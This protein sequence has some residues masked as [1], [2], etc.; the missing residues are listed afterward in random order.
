MDRRQAIRTLL[1]GGAAPVFLRGARRRPGDKP[2]LLFLWADQ[3]RADTMAAYGNH[4][5]RVPAMNKLASQSVV[6]ERCYASQPVCSPNRSSI[7][8]GLW[9][10][11][12]G[13]TTNNIALRGD[14]PTQPELLNDSDY[15][16]AFMGKWH[17]GD[18]IFPQHG[19]Q[20]WASIDDGYR[21]HYSKGRDPSARSSYYHY[22]TKQGYAPDTDKG[23]SRSFC[24]RLPMEHTKSAYIGQ[25][26]SDFILEN[27]NEP[28]LLNVMFFEPHG[29]FFGPLNDLHTEEEAP[30]PENYP[31]IPIA[32]E[33]KFY[34]DR[35]A[36]GLKDD[37]REVAGQRIH[38]RD[39]HQRANRN[40][41]GLC[42]QVDQALGQILWALEASGQA[43][44][45][46]IVYTADHGEMLGAHGI[47]GKQVMYEESVRVPFLLRVP[48]RQDQS[49]HI[50]RP[51][52]CTDITPTVLEL[53]GKPVP[54]E[55]QGESAAPL[56]EGT[57]RRQEDVFVEW[58]THYNW[59]DQ[60]NGR[61]VISPDGWKLI[62]HDSNENM[63]FN[64][65]QDPLEMNNLHGSSEHKDV[66]KRLRAHLEDWQR[67]VDDP[68]K[69][70]EPA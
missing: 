45:T 26:A 49:L 46:I 10:H 16:T 35:R 60:P 37:Y 21:D 57:E 34:K 22:L 18:E 3:Q 15:R 25:Q 23:F 58:H 67:Q 43:G 52:S 66:V 53:M 39:Y 51:V 56:L 44:N 36:E 14:T 61:T 70:P 69:M 4:R 62:L 68:I 11:T 27:R 13:C 9:P 33:P 2:N 8:T 32:G 29:P 41:A 7:M 17:L 42:S 64:R 6:F 20:K 5:Y 19:F 38:K 47:T 28:W 48:W 55:L 30:V 59:P 50:E 40:Y 24:V 12:T 63:L 1:A 54:A 31:G 65:Y